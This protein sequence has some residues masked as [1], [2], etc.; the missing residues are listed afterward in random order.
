MLGFST[1]AGMMALLA[2]LPIGIM[3]CFA[4]SNLEALQMTR[5]FNVTMMVL[6]VVQLKGFLAALGDEPP[7]R[8]L[9]ML[10]VAGARVPLGL[11]RQPLARPC[12]NVVSQ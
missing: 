8:S 3:L 10:A 4:S 5:L 11:L 1:I 12:S 7:P 2:T 9:Q 6:A